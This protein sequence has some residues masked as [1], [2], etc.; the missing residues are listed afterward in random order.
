MSTM[1]R[2]LTVVLGVD[3][4]D[5][6]LRYVEDDIE[7]KFRNFGYRPEKIEAEGTERGEITVM[8]TLTTNREKSGIIEEASEFGNC[9]WIFN[10]SE[11][12]SYQVN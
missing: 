1:A 12:A 11:V 4:T 9:Y 5:Q 8:V 3:S 10:N 2:E 7:Q 6:P